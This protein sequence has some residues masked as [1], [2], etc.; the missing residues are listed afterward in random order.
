MGYDLYPLTTLENKKKW[1]PEIA[2]EGWL[3]LF[4]HDRAMP[5][6]R[7][8]RAASAARNLAEPVPSRLIDV[9]QSSGYRQADWARQ[10]AKTRR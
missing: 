5:A 1:L 7:L 8:A 4:G 6:A 9:V 3:A 2:R 10:M